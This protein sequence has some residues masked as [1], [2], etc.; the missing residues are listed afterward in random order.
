L[1]PTLIRLALIPVFQAGMVS[2]LLYFDSSPHRWI[3]GD[4]ALAA[5]LV[6]FI[7]YMAGVYNAPL[8]WKWSRTLKAAV[9]TL[10]S[11]IAT[12]GGYTV[13]FVGE[14]WIKGEIGGPRSMS[15]QSSVCFCG[16]TNWSRF[17]PE[18]GGFS[19]SM[20]F[21]PTLST[22]TNDTPSGPLIMTT[23]TAEP[24]RV[25]A[26]SVFHNRFPPRLSTSN[27]QRLFE[28]GLKSAL[29]VDGRL[30]SD[31]HIQLHG[32]EGH[33]WK[34][35]KFKGQAVITMRV[36]LVNHEFFQAICLMPKNRFCS[37][38]SREYLDSFD[39]TDE[40]KDGSDAR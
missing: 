28:A 14:V 26:F 35:E 27:K 31:T 16:V 25:V 24:S 13:F 37:K 23:F 5:L 33:E 17:T 8:L 15:Y 11:V 29:G 1:L 7:A 4:F 6:P 2:G 20:P 34:F 32:Y 10:V 39:L 40:G 9:L 12:I 38:H 22:V 3:P 36:Y 19:V 18:Y 30:A 21:R